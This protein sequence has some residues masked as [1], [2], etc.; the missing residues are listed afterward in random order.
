[1]A[2]T[3]ANLWWVAAVGAGVSCWVAVR[4]AANLPTMFLLWALYH[5]LVNVGQTWYS[6]GES[7]FDPGCTDT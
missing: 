2:P 3:A 1:M 7:L 4:G 6:F 5:S